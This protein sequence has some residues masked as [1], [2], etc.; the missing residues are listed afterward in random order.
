MNRKSSKHLFRQRR[1]RGL[2][3]ALLFISFLIG[4][5][6]MLLEKDAPGSLITTPF[7]SVWW[8]VTTLTSIGYGDVV[9]ITFWGR[10]LGIIL[11]VMGA[12]MFSIIVAMIVNTTN[13]FQEEFYWKRLFARLDRIDEQLSTVN[14]STNFIVKDNGQE[15]ENE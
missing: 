5:G 3:V 13:R 14:K 2:L 6:V 15:P 7:D 12:V 8:V 4:A 1:F 11:Q 9:P 10:M